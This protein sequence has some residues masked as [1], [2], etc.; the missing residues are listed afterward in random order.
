MENRVSQVRRYL[1]Q[2]SSDEAM[3]AIADQNKRAKLPPISVAPYLGK[4]LYTLASLV[5]PRRILEVGT[6]GG[7]STLWLA[8]AL[9][10]EGKLISLEKF[11]EHALIA[12]DNICQAGFEKEVE[13]RIGDA[14][15][16]LEAMPLD[17]PFDVIFLDADKKRYPEYLEKIL[18]LARPG[19]LLLSDNLI[20]REEVVGVPRTGDPES[21]AIYRYNQLI[22]TRLETA[23]CPTVVG[24]Q[25]RL[26][27]LGVS[28]I[29]GCG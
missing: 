13:V 9:R 4:L 25:G 19:A 15:E 3:E 7:Y 26:D 27:A 29:K 2:L 14:M 17:A 8:R 20:P 22:A 23:F 18:K 11:A 21:E 5:Q 24:E 12:R 6:L 28:L 16:L 1:N 10:P